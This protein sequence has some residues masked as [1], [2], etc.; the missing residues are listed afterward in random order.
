LQA[1]ISENSIAVLLTAM[2]TTISEVVQKKKGS[3]LP[4]EKAMSSKGRWFQ[5][6]KEEVTTM[7]SVDP[8]EVVM[9]NTI[10]Q[11]SIGYNRVLYLYAKSYNKWRFEEV[12]LP[13]GV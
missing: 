4:D 5:V 10:F 2:Q 9:Q 1:D 12:K 11:D 3:V 13:G 6:K 8:F 7:K